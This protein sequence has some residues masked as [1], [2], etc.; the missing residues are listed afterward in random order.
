MAT[1]CTVLVAGFNPRKCPF[2]PR[3]CEEEPKP[4]DPTNFTV[5]CGARRTYLAKKFP[6][7]VFV[8]F[9]FETG[10]VRQAEGGKEEWKDVKRFSPITCEDNYNECREFRRNPVDRLSITDIYKR[11][12]AMGAPKSKEAGTL[13]E[14]SI[15]SHGTYE[16]PVLVNSFQ[17][18][19]IGTGRNSPMDKD[20]RYKKDFVPPTM[21]DDNKRA[22]RAAFASDGHIW[23]WGC[24]ATGVYHRV[25]QAMA[26]TP[27]FHQKKV[28]KW[29]EPDT[30]T[31]NFQNSKEERNACDYLHGFLKDNKSFAAKDGRRIDVTLGRLKAYYRDAIADTYAARITAAAGVRTYAASPGTWASVVVTDKQ[32]RLMHVRMSPEEISKYG[33]ENFSNFIA[34]YEN[35]LGLKED[36]ETRG[37]G[38]FRP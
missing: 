12:E 36:P 20:G 24:D 3:K 35:H 31:L 10:R 23:L 1:R 33:G 21:D 4:Y 8:L 19:A 25:F 9:E 2:N 16:G 14:L 29:Q 22:F 17:D 13:Y 7:M 26:R 30:F 18:G 38:T 11:V 34:F 37:Y 6:D 5:F 28:D 32:D 15:F 27:L